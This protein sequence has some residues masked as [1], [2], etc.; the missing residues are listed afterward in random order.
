MTDGLYGWC[1][2]R[3][4]RASGTGPVS[5]DTGRIRRRASIGRHFQLVMAVTLEHI[6]PGS[7]ARPLR[8]D[9]M[10]AIRAALGDVL[11]QH[12]EVIRLAVRFADAFSAYHGM[13]EV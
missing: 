8:H 7:R 5:Q 6:P 3:A 10:D 13:D 4:R 12:H 9:K 2:E 1:R 11:H